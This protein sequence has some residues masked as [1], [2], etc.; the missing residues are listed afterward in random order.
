MGCRRD[1]AQDDFAFRDHRIDHYRAEEV[2]LLAQI[3]D[4][5]GRFGDA[6]FHID[7]S[8]GRLGYTDFESVLLQSALQGT[9]DFPEL[10]LVFGVLADQIQTLQRADD[11]RHRERLGVELRTHVVA[12]QVDK[13][14]GTADEGSDA[15]HR[16]GEGVEQHI[17]TVHDAEVSGRAPSVGTHRAEAVGVIDQQAEVEIF[18][19]RHDLV[20][21]AQV[22]LH[23]E[24]AFGDDEYAAVLLLRQFR[25]VLELQ[26]QRRHVVMAIYETLALVHAQAVDDAGVCLGVIDHHVARGEQ[27]VDDRDHALIAEVQQ[28]GVGFADELCQFALQLFMVFGL[29]AHHAGAHR[30]C[31]AEFGGTF[32][33]GFAHFGVIGQAQV[34]VQA[35]VQHLLSPKGH[36]GTD[37]SFEFGECEI[38]VGITHVH[39]DR[40][41]GILFEAFKNIYHT[42][43]LFD[44]KI[45]RFSSPQK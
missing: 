2:V 40:A 27:A 36:V 1:Q 8:Y 34:V 12:Q 4:Q 15:G 30:G 39:T 6:A 10:L 14:A 43:S 7:G 33:V 17:H 3:D 19:H 13:P 31:H 5:V 38:P 41:S 16:L 28:E 32:G 45:M 23:A 26:A 42:S 29:T 24:Y 21:F 44:F 25:S 37:F 11:H 35:P 9:G 18:L 20:Q 22:A